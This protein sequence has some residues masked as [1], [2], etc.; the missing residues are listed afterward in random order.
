[1]IPPRRLFLIKG[2]K[3]FD[4]L[5]VISTFLLTT[6]IYSLQIRIVSF[7]QLFAI[8]VSIKGII[9]ISCLLLCWHIL[10]SVFGLYQSWRGYSRLREFR[11]IFMATSIGILGALFM[12][13]L[14]KF[15]MI[16]PSFLAVFWLQ[17]IVI[18]VSSRFMLR[19]LLAWI[20]SRGRKL[21]FVVIV[22]T[23]QEGI[24]L[25][26]VIRANYGL[27]YRL[28]GF[29]GSG[30]DE[31]ERHRES[32]D[33]IV[34]DFNRFPYFARDHIIDEVWIAIPITSYSQQVLKIETLCHKLGI[35][36]RFFPNDVDSKQNRI[37]T[38][39]F[40][41]ISVIS[42]Y[43]G[44]QIGFHFVVKRFMDITI[45][46]LLLVLL[47]PLLLAV[48]V[49]IKITSH[50]PAIYIQSRIG[51]NE[52]KFSMFK[53]RTMKQN[54]ENEIKE[55][56]NLNEVTGPVLKIR[57]DPRITAVGKFLRRTSIDEIPQLMNVLRGEMSLVGPRPLP[58]RDFE[59]FY[60]DRHFRRFSV[61]P[62]L[63]CLW[64]TNGRSSIPF[65]K[66][67]DLDLQYIDQW[68]LRLDFFILLR[69]IPAVFR[70]SGAA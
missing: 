40:D 10:F 25:S 39:L 67:M 23:N 4:L 62:G 5:I 53:F 21:R 60:Q 44:A 26:Q 29:I 50:G 28:L 42:R 18:A 58:I 13:K 24:K 8:Q 17:I 63:T 2:F 37:K 6:W 19:W 14:F 48:A 54:A 66:W 57:N 36:I 27:G 7:K 16:T 1:M 45:S 51:L 38:V 34:S 59:R 20:R 30:W 15:G 55:L 47:S 35:I 68:S 43:P 3:L 65:E 69:T 70:G 64:Q 46:S 9:F 12:A 33:S 49:W 32:L 61:L 41:N 52:R 31:N 56:E 22:G 11:C